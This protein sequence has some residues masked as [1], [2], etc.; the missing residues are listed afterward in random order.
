MLRMLLSFVSVLLTIATFIAQAAGDQKATELLSKA[1][2]AIGGDQALRRVQ[3]LSCSGQVTRAIAD[4]QVSGELT[5]D[6]QLPDKLLRTESISPMGDGAL[7]LTEQGVNGETLLRGFKTF[8]TPPGAIIRQPPP[9][10][11][12]SEAEAQALR[13]S[14]AELARLAIALLLTA[15]DRMTVEFTYAGEAE[16]PDGKA[17]VLDV[18]GAGGFA[19]KL[20]LDRS[21]HRPLMLAYRGVA[22]RMVVHTSPSDPP[23]GEPAAGAP[24]PPEVVDIN[25]YFDDHRNVDGLL[26]PHHLTRTVAGQ[27]VEE[28]TFKTI[29]INPTFKPDT[30]AA[31]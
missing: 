1:R 6:M 11:P 9:P 23:P 13:N 19:A 14:R 10:P 12:G 27:M 24:P 8:N 25:L 29:R 3:G 31:K 28:W 21:S 7:V 20:L 26:L 2:A 22:P 30:F 4:H 5:L 18:K 17:D 16:S 15:P